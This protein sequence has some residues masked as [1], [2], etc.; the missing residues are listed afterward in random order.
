M[1]V[2]PIITAALGMVSKG[3]KNMVRQRTL[4][5]GKGSRPNLIATNYIKTKS[6]KTLRISCRFNNRENSESINCTNIYKSRHGRLGIVIYSE[7]C[8]QM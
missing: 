3:L 7:L 2:I 1:T 4:K 6:V 8:K 5:D